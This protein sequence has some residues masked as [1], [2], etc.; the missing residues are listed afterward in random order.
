[1]LKLVGFAFV[2]S[3]AAQVPV[4]TA[5]AMAPSPAAPAP[6][7]VADFVPVA[8]TAATCEVPW[9]VN[10]MGRWTDCIP[11]T[12]K[13]EGEECKFE[14]PKQYKCVY[15]GQPI[16]I[17]C[18]REGKFEQF[19][20]NGKSMGPNYCTKIPAP[21]DGQGCAR[22]DRDR[23]TCTTT[24]GCHWDGE[25]GFCSINCRKVSCGVE[26]HRRDVA[27]Q[28]NCPLHNVTECTPWQ[29]GC[30]CVQDTE[31]KDCAAWCQ[32]TNM[33]QFTWLPTEKTSAASIG[34]AN[35]IKA[36]ETTVAESLNY[37]NE[38]GYEPNSLCKDACFQRGVCISPKAVIV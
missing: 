6:T 38:A 24:D 14:S 20:A 5:N 18:N 34:S 9:P 1:M 27:C 30:A 15:D 17:K 23:S 32:T 8:P 11:E 31:I 4:A 25:R 16:A 35:A 26:L 12:Y 10:G 3:V 28:F 21:A 2:A 19:D 22:Y 29:A 37:K 36:I 7:K 13:S 33:N